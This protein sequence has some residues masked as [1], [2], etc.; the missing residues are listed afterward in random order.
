MSQR[1]LT[2]AMLIDDAAEIFEVELR[3]HRILPNLDAIIDRVL[4]SAP[5][6]YRTQATR[7]LI[8]HELLLILRSLVGPV[9]SEAEIGSG[10]GIQ[11]APT[12]TPCNPE[13]DS[14]QAIVNKLKQMFPVYAAEVAAAFAAIN[15]GDDSTKASGQDFISAPLM[16]TQFQVGQQIDE[17]RLL[18]HLGAGGMGT[19]WKAA[20]DQPV[21]REVAIKFLRTSLAPEI[22]QDRFRFERQA[23]AVLNHPNVAKIIGA[24]STG[25]GYPYLVMELVDGLDIVSYCKHESLNLDTRLRLFVDVC[26]GVLH[27]HQHGILHRDIK[28]MNI[29]VSTVDAMPNPKLIDFGLAKATAAAAHRPIDSHD[30]RPSAGDGRLYES[31]ANAV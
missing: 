2:Q 10:L 7:S 20:Q 12:G 21:R 26:R 28:P 17:Y 16:G 25:K 24:G 5:K 22:W 1:E 15:P 18:E 14:N 30:H 8:A 27:A 31:R 4:A 6:E 29:L 23:L 9:I 11:T 19:V 13:T 3:R